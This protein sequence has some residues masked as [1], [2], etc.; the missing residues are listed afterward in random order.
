M[1]ILA[2]P[3]HALRVADQILQIGFI[4]DAAGT[5]GVFEDFAKSGVLFF[6]VGMIGD[7]PDDGFRFLR[8]AVAVFFEPPFCERGGKGRMAGMTGIHGIA[9]VIMKERGAHGGSFVFTAR[10]GEQPAQSFDLK[11]VRDGCRAQGSYADRG[12][13]ADDMLP[14]Q[15]E[16][17][18]FHSSI[19]AQ[20]PTC[21]KKNR[22]D[23]KAGR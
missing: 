5:V 4:Q 8:R 21:A 16:S 12:V 19:L 23:R 14:K 2:N 20:I 9:A 22:P 1:Q 10:I 7:G 17:F 6:F 18:L 3:F 11:R 15:I 13:L